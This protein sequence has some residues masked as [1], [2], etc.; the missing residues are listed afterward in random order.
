MNRFSRLLLCLSCIGFGHATLFISSAAEAVPEALETA[1][2][3]SSLAAF[4][5]LFQADSQAV[6][7][8]YDLPWSA[9]RFERLET[10]YRD[11]QQKLSCV[12]FDKLEQQGRVDYVLLRNR[13]AAEVNQI[14]LE[15]SRLAEMDELVAW[16]ASVQEL[17]RARWR[18]QPLNA[19]AAADLVAK[20]PDQLKELRQRL[21]KGKK[22]EKHDE[23]TKQPADSSKSASTNQTSETN[24][25]K[26]SGPA[27]ESE[28]S[29]PLKV[30]PLLGKRAAEATDELRGTLKNWYSFYEGYQPDFS[31]WVKKPYEEANHALEEYRNDSLL[32]PGIDCHWR[33]GVCLV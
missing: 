8:F 17:E 29:I 19:Q 15:R 9:T 26:D 13:L 22:E 23:K 18:M 11:W 16:R 25:V 7:R 10:L 12:E 33:E 5:R 30:S 2:A 27:T 21:E 14:S 32:S 6:S 31:W 24:S 3:G 4:I 1:S 28:K 20:L